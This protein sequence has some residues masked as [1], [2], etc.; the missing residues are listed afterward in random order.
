L[1]RITTR[2]QTAN[3]GKIIMDKATGAWS[4][5]EAIIAAAQRMEFPMRHLLFMAFF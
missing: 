2:E 5:A 3:A 4:S 1:G